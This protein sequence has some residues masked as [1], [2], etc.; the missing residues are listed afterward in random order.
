MSKDKLEKTKS[1][2]IINDLFEGVD[3][4]FEKVDGDIKAVRVQ[5][6]VNPHVFFKI[7][8]PESFSTTLDVLIAEKNKMWFVFGELPGGIVHE[9]VF[10]IKQEA[11]DRARQL[12][13]E[14]KSYAITF[15]YE[16][17]EFI[18]VDDK[19]AA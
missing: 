5:D 9:E 16:E 10:D 1:E 7:Q 14:Y 19:L 3:V 13:N 11:I 18:E 6:A 17:R 8:N 2:K 4:V 12:D 15:D